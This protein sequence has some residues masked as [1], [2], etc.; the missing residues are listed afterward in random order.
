LDESR[1]KKCGSCSLLDRKRK[2]FHGFGVISLLDVSTPFAL[3][4]IVSISL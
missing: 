1:Q 2:K 4:Q 3:P